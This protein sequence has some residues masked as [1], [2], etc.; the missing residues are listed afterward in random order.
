MLEQGIDERRYGAC[1]GENNEGTKK[2]E[3]KHNRE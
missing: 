1:F 3:Y 2:E